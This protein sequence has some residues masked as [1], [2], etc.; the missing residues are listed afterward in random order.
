MKKRQQ[1]PINDETMWRRQLLRASLN[2]NYFYFNL[3]TFFGL[4]TFYF[5]RK[6]KR[7]C[8]SSFLNKYCTFV[9]ISFFVLYP[10]AVVVLL[11]EFGMNAEMGFTDI[12]RNSV[13]I[14]NWLMC[15]LIFGNQ[16]KHAIESC[17]LYNQAGALYI[18]TAQ[19]AKARSDV[20][21]K[22]SAKC[23]LKTCILTIGFLYVNFVKFYHHI[24]DHISI[25]ECLLF[26][27]LFVPSFIMALASNRIHVATTL[28]TLLIM[29]IET[30]I[31]RLSSE[32]ERKAS[33]RHVLK[34]SREMSAVSAG[35]LSALSESYASLHQIFVDF[36]FLYAK[37]TLFILG[38]C[39][40]N[41]VFEVSEK[42]SKVKNSDFFPALLSLPEHFVV[43]CE[44]SGTGSVFCRFS[45]GANIFVLLRNCRYNTNL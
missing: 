30:S 31:K 45:V 5:S 25:L 2:V 34:L 27:Y 42:S 18:D 9:A 17:N 6:R 35:K 32:F 26:I 7:F 40:V 8:D 36:N 1:F 21:L 33:N 11:E 38:I 23:A 39:F 24:D 28:C 12:T 41:V 19:K 3:S 10:V 44:R 29:D 15:A 22:Y 4:T 16:A 13:Y 20:K 37:C 14:G 43:D